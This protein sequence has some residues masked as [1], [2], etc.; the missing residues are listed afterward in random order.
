[1]PIILAFMQKSA[2]KIMIEVEAPPRCPQRTKILKHTL[3]FKLHS[4]SKEEQN[5]HQIPWCQRRRQMGSAVNVETKF[6]SAYT[7]TR[8]HTILH[9]RTSANNVDIC[10]DLSQ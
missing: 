3:N 7:C 4:F 8:G 9:S 2:K 6:L 1:M 10:T 5:A